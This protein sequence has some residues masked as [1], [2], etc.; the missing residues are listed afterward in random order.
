VTVIRDAAGRYFASFI[1]H[2]DPAADAARFPAAD[3]D[4]NAAQNILA[5][6]RRERLNACG[7]GIRP[8]LAVAAVSETGT[9]RGAA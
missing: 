8:P 4:H 7:D 2:T 6:G 9:L 5:L 1:V 3:R